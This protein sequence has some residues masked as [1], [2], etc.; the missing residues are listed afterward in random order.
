[1]ELWWSIVQPWRYISDENGLRLARP[2]EIGPEWKNF[3][4]LHIGLY[5]KTIDILLK[6]LLGVNLMD[7]VIAHGFYRIIEVLSG[8]RKYIDEYFDS[9]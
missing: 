8:C 9:R 1:M 3:I 5:T 6:S 4:H 2:S 7:P